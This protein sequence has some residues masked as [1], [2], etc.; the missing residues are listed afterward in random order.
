MVQ[1]KS[2]FWPVFCGG[3]ECNSSFSS[4][5]GRREHCVQIPS[6][7]SLS[8]PGAAVV[9]A[10]G[11][12]SD[13][14]RFNKHVVRVPSRCPVC[15]SSFGSAEATAPEVSSNKRAGMLIP[16]MTLGPKS[17]KA[18]QD[19][20]PFAHL[21]RALL[22]RLAANDFTKPCCLSAAYVKERRAGVLQGP[23]LC[24]DT[25]TGELLSCS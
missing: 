3:S 12:L 24:S 10:Q 19:R 6:P 17:L 8:W 2:H 20:L 23:C 7:S 22:L 25:A 4:V 21:R 1:T 16:N 11:V 18:L 14:Q 13:C 9:A 15:N 5:T